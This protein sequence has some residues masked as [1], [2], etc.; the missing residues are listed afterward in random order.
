MALKKNSKR[1]RG[2][3]LFIV[4][5]TCGSALV[6]A[7]ATFSIHEIGEVRQSKLGE[8]TLAASLIGANSTAALSFRDAQA[9]AETLETLKTDR[10]IIAARIYD[11]Q[12]TPFATWLRPGIHDF[13]VPALAEPD[14]GSFAGGVLRLSSGIYQDGRL[15]GSVFL[16]RDLDEL[17]T[18]ILRY[19]FI[20]G[21]VRL[22]SMLFAFLL[23]TR[24]QR[25]ISD[26]ILVLA[27]R[28]GSIR[29]GADYALGDVQG[30]YQEIG[31]LIESFNGMLG[32]IKRRD[33]E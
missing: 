9:A 24:L 21:G 32:T 27:R 7:G 14:A 18:G 20:A 30:G 11:A 13:D 5:L 6:F 2:K 25:G 33:T 4:M 15:V 8:M 31:L 23:A 28:A 19:V 22:A 16:E 29:E 1:L 10:H 26:P 17:H 12:G 3:L